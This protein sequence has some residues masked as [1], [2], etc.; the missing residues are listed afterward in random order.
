MSLSRSP[1]FPVLLFSTVCW[2]TTWFC[3]H[4]SGW[5]FTWP[6]A[7]V[8]TWFTLLTLALHLW[9]ERAAPS[10]IKGFIRRF[11]AGLI[12]KLLLSLLV[13]ALLL[14]KLPPGGERT[15]FVMAFALLYLA[16]LGFSTARLV[17]ILKQPGA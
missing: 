15:P 13:L 10:D 14:H 17:G 16:F 5:S 3:V 6:Y 8:L 11:M 12:L 7:V 9:Q 4:W 2:A 1:L